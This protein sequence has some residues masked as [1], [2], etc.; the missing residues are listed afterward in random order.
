MEFTMATHAHPTA[1]FGASAGFGG[2]F[3]SLLARYQALRSASIEQA[4]IRR[5][6]ESYTDRQLSD[7]GLSRLDIPAVAA[8][9]FSR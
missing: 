3:Q 9:H 6:L 8:G 4:R 7:L 1:S 2:L 5:E